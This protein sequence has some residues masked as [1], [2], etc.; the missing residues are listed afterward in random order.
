MIDKIFIRAINKELSWN[1]PIIDL[2]DSTCYNI[3]FS[4]KKIEAFL[5]RGEITKGVKFF[6][7][8]IG[9]YNI[10]D[11]SKSVFDQIIFELVS[12]ENI[13]VNKIQEIFG[14]KVKIKLDGNLLSANYLGNNQITQKKLEFISESKLDLSDTNNWSCRIP[15]L[16]NYLKS[17]YRFFSYDH[18]Y[19]LFYNYGWLEFGKLTILGLN[20]LSFRAYYKYDIDEISHFETIVGNTLSDFEKVKSVLENKIGGALSEENSYNQTFKHYFR[21]TIWQSDKLEIRLYSTF[22]PRAEP[23]Q[24]RYK[25]E[26]KKPASNK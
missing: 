14:E 13:I 15:N 25:L 10:C 22:I 5:S 17:E 19:N 20:H 2:I 18:H 24:L 1:T 8:H 4:D 9:T 12:P 11:I 6:R 21:N 7:A 23:E 26:I 16:R 3:N